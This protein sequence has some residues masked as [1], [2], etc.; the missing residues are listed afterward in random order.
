MTNAKATGGPR[1]GPGV[2]GTS[3]RT[4]MAAAFITG[5]VKTMP[6]GVSNYK[7]TVSKAESKAITGNPE[8]INALIK[9]YGRAV[10][11]SM[12]RGEQVSFRV[13]IDPEGEAI[14]TTFED[15]AI[16]GAS[17]VEGPVL[18]EDGAP[19]PELEI[20]LDAARER[21]RLRVTEILSG[22]D[23]LSADN[24]AKVL[25]VSR[26]TVNTKRQNGQILGLTGAKRGYR[27]PLWQIDGDGKPYSLLPELHEL[28]GGPWAVY[29][30][31]VQ[32][33]GALEGMTGREALERGKDKAVLDAAE[34]AG[35]DFR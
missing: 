14:V 13:D 7:L 9:A 18:E 19:D 8:Q 15:A 20:A 22:D 12:K 28:L 35:R 17:A 16:P 24:L 25:G 11:Q 30:F 5:P 29:R 34:G 26:M 2:T 6:K 21:G 23:M 27:F 31:L 4:R 33:H 32:P 3:R 10:V 1:K